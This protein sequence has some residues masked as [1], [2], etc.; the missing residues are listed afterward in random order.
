MLPNFFNNLINSSM[1]SQFSILFNFLF[2]FSSLIFWLGGGGE[3][4]GVD[5]LADDSVGAI[6]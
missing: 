6:A 5:V 1:L 4:E 3:W 2:F